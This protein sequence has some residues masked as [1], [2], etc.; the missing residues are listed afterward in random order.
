[1]N[2]RT[3]THLMGCVAVSLIL[4]RVAVATPAAVGSGQ[5]NLAGA[6]Y[7]TNSEI[8][9]GYK[10]APPNGDQM[11]GVLL[12]SNGAFAGLKAGDM[13]RIGNLQTPSAGGPVT[14]GTPFLLSNW[15]Q[16]SNNIDADLTNIPLNASIAVCASGMEGL[17]SV[18]R[19][20][21]QSPVILEQGVTG[22]T[23]FLSVMG[24]A[25]YAG[26]TV[27]TPLMGL[28]SANFTMGADSTISGLLADYNRNGFIMTGYSGNFSTTAA[29]GVPEPASL[30]LLSMSLI[31]IALIGRK[32]LVRLS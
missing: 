9:F 31:G 30:G 16:L 27:D 25:H 18:C 5:F 24:Q 15:I 14:P 2:L 13:A 6:V 26:S 20:N 32:K 22:V 1:M 28:L 8:L 17:G 3:I 4:S 21:A 10:Q 11:A 7:V 23:A 12:P 19:V 29:A